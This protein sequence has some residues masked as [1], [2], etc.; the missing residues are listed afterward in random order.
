MGERLSRKCH[1]RDD[2]KVFADG[3]T[4]STRENE[5]S[6]ACREVDVIAVEK[7]GVATTRYPLEI[8]R[9]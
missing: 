2:G 9:Y 5:T 8:R 1:Y 6:L 7:D 3:F 4:T